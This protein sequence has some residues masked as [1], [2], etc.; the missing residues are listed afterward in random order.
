M[1]AAPTIMLSAG[2]PS[3][4]VHGALLAAA[5]RRRWPDVR[6]FGLGG[7]RMAEQGVD[8][9]ADF[10]RLSVMGFA[11]VVRH[12][13]FFVRLLRRVDRELRARGTDL[14][15]PIDYPGFNFRLAKRAG[16]ARVP[17]LYYI[18]PQVW[19]WHRSR[20]R[21][22]AELADRLAVVFPFEE[23]VFREA[24]ARARFVGHPL[25]DQPEAAAGLRAR[26]ALH[27]DAPVLALFPGSRTQEV[28]RH[29]DLFVKA[30]ERVRA[31]LPEVQP[32][33]ATVGAVPA[34]AY[35]EAPY[36]TT[37]ESRALLRAATAALVKSGTSTI[38]AALALTPMVIAYRTSRLT[39][40]IARR[41][42]EVDHI[43]MVNLIARERV[44]PE[45]VQDEA[46]PSAL[47]DALLP[48]LDRGDPV[49][50][51]MVGRLGG[52]RAA[53]RHTGAG[54]ASV[55]GRVA[56]MAGELLDTRG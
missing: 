5:L 17:V 23:A 10:D 2:E 30:A 7:P 51:R 44:A 4:D 27:P 18:A 40:A 19:A 14:V 32:V 20:A 26:L 3:G 47:A 37:S 52:I 6:L 54:E 45:F 13:P 48:L 39:H 49:R 38:E 41:V 35:R 42:V 43:G 1:G 29:L 16:A 36:P 12:L 21:Q 28:Q 55:A 9:L 15:I 46:T 11:E 24:G 22:L 8:L 25:L 34:A 50:A 33:I 53:L 56:A 31:A